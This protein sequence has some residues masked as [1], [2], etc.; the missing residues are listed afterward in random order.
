MSYD[1]NQ[2]IDAI[3]FD[4]DAGDY[5]CIVGENGSGKSTLVKTIL[6]IVSPQR[7]SV[8]FL[9]GLSK[10]NIG[11]LPQQTIERRDFPAS[12]YEVVLSGCLN[13]S[14][15]CPFYS[16]KQKQLARDAMRRLSIESLAGRPIC[17]LSGGQR[18]RALLARALCAGQRMIVL[19]EPSAGLDPVVTAEL[20]E[21]VAELN[22][23]S[24]VTI[25]MVSHDIRSAVRYASK[26]LH[27][28]TTLVYCGDVA[29]YQRSEAGR[30]FLG[31]GEGA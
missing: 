8:T 23:N 18:Q 15:L 28:D 6:G 7:G 11:Y 13:S 16:R 24:G 1:N 26:I 29:G 17:E 30:R 27:L 12:V 2:A 4:I 5:V 9:N 21:I 25:V 31:G 14:G 19:D 10:N 20:Y 22:R 3:S